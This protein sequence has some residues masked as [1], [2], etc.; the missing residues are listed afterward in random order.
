MKIRA[1]HLLCVLG[2]RGKGYNEEF[3]EN[4]DSV[5]EKLNYNPTIEIL[6]SPDKICGKCPHMKSFMCEKEHYIKTL[7]NKVVSALNIDLGSRYTYETIL[8][9]IKNHM[10]LDIHEKICKDCSWY[11]L[12]LCAEGIKNI[13]NRG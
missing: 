8:R 9:L 12:G 10:T 5:V 3:I 1:H 11:S 6:T 4:M 13:R 2:Y 7:D